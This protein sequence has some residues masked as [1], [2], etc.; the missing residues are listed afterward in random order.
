KSPLVMVSALREEDRPSVAQYLETLGAPAYLE[1][2]SGLR[3]DPRLRKLRI[4]APEGVLERASRAGYPVD[5]VLRIGG[6]PT[7]RLW[8]DLENMNGKIPV[9]SVSREPF[10][11]LSWAPLVA[12][13][14]GRLFAA[15]V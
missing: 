8:R 4:H 10:A 3:E 14:P 15:A 12:I 11:G 6:V 13:D 5:G 2:V 7:P 9:C 1:A